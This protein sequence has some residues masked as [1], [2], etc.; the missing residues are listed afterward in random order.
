MDRN[1]ILIE[2]L[3]LV[4]GVVDRLARSSFAVKATASAVATA[5][6]AVIVIQEEASVGFGAFVL[7]ALWALDAYYLWK[8]RAYRKL[9]EHVRITMPTD[10]EHEEFLTLKYTIVETRRR[11]WIYTMISSSLILFH[12][13]L[14]AAA[15]VVSIINL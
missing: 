14:A 13:P 3:K 12:I 2:H 6:I 7:V 10:P 5:L 15:V 8:E 1:Q 9:Y 4:E 11:G